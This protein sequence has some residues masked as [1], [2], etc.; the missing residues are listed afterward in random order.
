MSEKIAHHENEHHRK[1]LEQIKPPEKPS[2]TSEQH[3]HQKE[4]LE[5]IRS[6][7]EQHAQKTETIKHNQ[8]NKEKLDYANTSQSVKQIK[9]EAY[10]N[11]LKTTQKKLKPTSRAFSKFIHSKPVEATSVALEKTVARPQSI[12]YGGFFALFGS[13]ILYV[14]AKRYGFSY[15]FLVYTMLYV[16]FYAF[17]LLIEILVKQV[18]K[19][20][21]R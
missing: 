10:K 1:H 5:S 16:A 2:Q 4:S 9:Q 17:G 14:M 13:A 20:T 11:T 15:N 18:Q 6:S 12:L 19:L 8:D 7:I 21:N 3:N